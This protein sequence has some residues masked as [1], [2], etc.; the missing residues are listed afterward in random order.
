M[1]TQFITDDKGKKVSVILSIKK[2]D[3]ILEDLEELEDIRAYDKVKNKSGEANEP[4]EDY[5]RKRNN[6]KKNAKI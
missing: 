1:K 6:R 5:L 3:R 4:L 2:Y